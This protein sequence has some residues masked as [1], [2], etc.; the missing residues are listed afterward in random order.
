MAKS[1][2]RLSDVQEREWTQSAGTAVV[3][4]GILIA[5]ALIIYFMKFLPIPES[6]LLVSRV[7]AGIALGVG[8]LLMLSAVHRSFQA[9]IAKHVTFT[10]PF[11]DKENRF[12]EAPTSD[13]DCEHCD[14]TV[15]FENGKPIPVH[16]VACQACRTEHRVAV[17]VSHYVCDSCNRPLRL[18]TDPNFTQAVVHEREVSTPD[19]LLRNYDVLLVAVDRR[20]ENDVAFKL[21]NMLVVSLKESR[22]LIASASARTPLIIAFDQPQRKAEVIRRQLQELGATVTLRPTNSVPR[23]TSSSR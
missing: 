5:S 23:A 18:K 6:Q 12:V 3:G 22:N 17:N 19:E 8:G 4:V 7:I 13:F 20:R 15:H 21:Q 16:T 11:C 1:A 9:K 10:C 2:T 14:R